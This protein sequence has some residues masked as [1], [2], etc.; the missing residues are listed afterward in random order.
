[1]YG[2]QKVFFSPLLVML[3]PRVYAKEFFF[4]LYDSSLATIEKSKN[5][6]LKNHTCMLYEQKSG[7]FFFRFS[8]ANSEGQKFLISEVS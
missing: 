6:M 3:A 5:R 4:L 2:V 7:M 8:K 1:M